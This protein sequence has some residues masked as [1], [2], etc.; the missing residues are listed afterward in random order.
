MNFKCSKCGKIEAVSTTNPCC[1]CGGLW[2]LENDIPDFKTDLIDKDEWSMY[3]YRAF[4]ALD[5]DISWRQTNLGEGLTPIIKYNDDIML[6]MDYMMPTLS[7]K[8]RGA[9]ALISHCKSIGVKEI[10][11]DSSGNAGNA[12]AAYAAKANIKC[13]IYVPEGTSSAKINMIKAHGAECIV[14]PGS[15]DHC[16]DVCRNQVK[17]TGAYYAN[18]VYNP[19]FYEGT[20]TYIYEVY[21]QLHRIP[22]NLI[23]PVGNGT[24]FLGVIYGLEH[25]YKSKCIDHFPQIW[26][27]QSEKCSPLFNAFENNK[28]EPEKVK[29]E[30]TL[31]EG[32]AIGEP[33]RGR[34]ILALA[35]KYNV[36]F[37]TAA[38][39]KILSC[40]SD[41]AKKGIYIEHTTAANL[42]AYQNTKDTLIVMCGAGLKSDH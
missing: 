1:S 14:V 20:K 18:H 19:F 13:K 11:Q 30:K 2:D 4:M 36:K 38:E 32:I 15:R 5:D 28:T 7:F 17:E 3:R 10:V 6:K 31:A 27:L 41:L 21:E 29:I 25:L 9:S 40:R 42:A 22:E 8:D 26:A 34:E 24:L 39:D 16:A 23:I 37:V 12:V 35:K 33:M